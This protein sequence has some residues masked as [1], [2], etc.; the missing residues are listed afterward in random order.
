MLPCRPMCFHHFRHAPKSEIILRHGDRGMRS[1]EAL[2]GMA[3]VN[4]SRSKSRSVGRR[5]IMK[6]A[7]GSVQDLMLLEAGLPKSL[8]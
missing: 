3:T 5:V 4:P 8:D 2:L 1:A 7:F 6:E